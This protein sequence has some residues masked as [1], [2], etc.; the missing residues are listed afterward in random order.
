MNKYRAADKLLPSKTDKGQKRSLSKINSIIVHTTGYGVGLKRIKER[1]EGDLVA[2]GSVYAKRMAGILKYKGHFLIDHVGV[3]YHLIPLGEVAWHTGSGIRKKLKT[4]KPRGWWA[5]RWKNLDNPTKL[6]S[7]KE[8]S[9]NKVSVGIDLLAHGNGAIVK[10]YT[11][12]QYESLARLVKALC[13]DLDIPVEREYIVGHE[14][15]DPISRGNKKA[16]WDPGK[17]D[18]NKLL[19]LASPEEQED[20]EIK[21]P[22]V[23]TGPRSVVAHPLPVS[24]FSVIKD[25]FRMFW[26]K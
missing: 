12:A 3:I 20:P 7:W 13:E 25:L 9:P 17:F 15:V 5:R 4:E 18:Y 1:N 16:G 14:D 19:S 8:N 11:D 22:H 24:V 6:P 10:G 2:I 21:L 23:C 26:Y